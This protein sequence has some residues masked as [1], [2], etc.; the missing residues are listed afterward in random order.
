MLE[1][2]V[3]NNQDQDQAQNYWETNP[4]AAYSSSQWTSNPII[5]E[6]VYQRM[7]GGQS[8]KHW[9]TWLIEDYFAGQKFESLLS[10][11]CG[12]GDHEVIV[13]KSG[14]VKTI[15]A[16]DFSQASLEIARQNASNAGATIN[17]YQD[18][19]NAFTVIDEK[20]YDLVLCSGSLHHVKELERFLAIIQ[21]CL[22][23]NGY[24]IINEYVGDCYNI[25]NKQQIKI[26]NRLYKCFPDVLR[27][28]ARG[29]FQNHTIEQAIATDPSECVRSKLILPFLE[30]YFDMEV[31][32]PFGGGLL[33]P[34]YPLLDHNQFLDD[35]NP[36]ALTILKLL[37]EFEAILMEM[38]GGLETDFCLSILRHKKSG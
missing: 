9:L 18:D 20:K 5:A 15:D 36:A 13:A 17:F 38:P 26:I 28:G 19:L 11:G 34:L 4:N 2:S 14:I 30:N 16:F 32:H 33:H 21:K 29:E 27:A 31:Y 8:K 3:T 35:K 12:I 6:I 7:S 25:Y 1:K 22:K 37:L 23:S 24:F 10:P